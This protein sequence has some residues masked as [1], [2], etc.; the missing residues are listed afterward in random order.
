MGLSECVVAVIVELKWIVH[1]KVSKRRY[2]KMALVLKHNGL[3]IPIRK[4]G[5]LLFIASH[6]FTIELETAICATHSWLLLLSED[7]IH[8]VLLESFLLLYN[9]VLI[10]FVGSFLSVFFY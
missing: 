1:L 3:I 5:P 2:L 6:T 4:E 9:I 7:H 10:L 8:E